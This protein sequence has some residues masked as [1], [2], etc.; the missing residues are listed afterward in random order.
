MRK[1]IKEERDLPFEVGKTYK[2]KF[3]TGETFTITS[4]T[5]NKYDEVIAIHGIYDKSP[6]LGQCPIGIGRLIPFTELTGNDIVVH[7]CPH[8]KKN[9]T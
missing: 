9:H 8:C 6:N 4:I 5:N 7:T 3:A 2:T 1:V